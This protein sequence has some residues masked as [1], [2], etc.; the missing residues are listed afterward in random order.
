MKKVFKT[1]AAAFLPTILTL[2]VF[3]A[4]ALANTDDVSG[5]WAEIQIEEWINLGYISGYSDGTFRP[6]N[7]I[8]R[9]EFSTL[10]NKAFKFEIKTDINF[11][12]VKPDYWAY[13]EIQKG[14][15]AGYVSGD[16]NETFR[17]DDFI[18]RQ[19]A[20]V[21]INKLL[22]NTE[23]EENKSNFSDYYDIDEWAKNSVDIVC[24]NGILLGFPDGTYR[25]QKHMTRAE[26]VSALRRL[27]EIKGEDDARKNEY[28]LRGKLLKD[29]IIDGDLIIKDDM[30]TVKLEG[31]TV[32]GTV[33]ANG[34]NVIYAENCNINKLIIDKVDF[35]FEAEKNT[36]VDKTE[37]NSCGKISGEGFDEVII[38]GVCNDEIIIDADVKN[39]VHNAKTDIFIGKNADIGS[40]KVTENAESS[41][42]KFERGSKVKNAEV[43]SKIRIV[44]E[45]EICTMEVYASGVESSIRPDSVTTADGALDPHYTELRPI[46]KGENSDEGNLTVDK[47]FDGKGKNYKNVTITDNAVVNDINVSGD[48]IIENCDVV[49]EDISVEGDI[50]VC[51]IGSVE[52]ED[53]LVKKDIVTSKDDEFKKIV[54]DNKTKLYGKLIIEGNTEISSECDVTVG[55]VDIKSNA[56]INVNIDKMNVL[57][58]SLIELHDGKTIEYVDI[59]DEAEVVEFNMNGVS[60]FIEDIESEKTKIKF[61]GIG[62]VGTVKTGNADNIT[63]DSGITINDIISDFVPVNN[64]ILAPPEGKTGEVLEL[65]LNIEPKNASN[66]DAVYEIVDDGGTGAE[67][68]GNKL[69]ADKSGVIKI[70]VEIEDGIGIGV[71]YTKDCIVEI[72]D[73]VIPVS[74]IIMENEVWVYAGEELE[75]EAYVEPED[76]TYNEIEWSVLDGYAYIEGNIFMHDFTDSETV[77]RIL[78]EVENGAADGGTFSREFEITVI[79]SKYG[80]R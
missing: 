52:L 21:I 54:F 20:A 17:P 50:I 32:K 78:A 70:K 41:R 57:S 27:T 10:V 73:N 29:E 25:P 37:L 35:V 45:G 56:D 61:R 42:I 68:N 76:A 5:H 59:F 65:S 60:S 9:A 44:G 12:D 28:I 69:A 62:Q 39:V 26:A 34:G 80:F 31:V 40:L 19:E 13:G 79:P 71:P 18:T 16:K 51:G 64:V 43:Y 63:T 74:E 2:T 1:L 30:D 67:I 47:D 15:S 7:S 66:K 11:A 24:E 46:S 6:D 58:D 14:I 33:Y 75:L 53:C 22:N 36:A 4:Q 55:E 3:N 8:T 72:K 38:D 77:V 23:S 48:I 49:L